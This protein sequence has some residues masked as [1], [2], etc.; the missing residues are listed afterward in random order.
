MLRSTL[1]FALTLACSMAATAQVYK[2]RKGSVVAYQDKP[3][4]R[5]TQLGK[6]TLEAAPVAGKTASS[7][8]SP[9][10]PVP[11]TPPASAAPAPLPQAQNYLCVRYDGSSYFTG[12]NM[13]RRHFVRG[14]DLKIPRPGVAPTTQ[15]WVTDECKV[16][17]L[18]DACTHYEVQILAL[19]QKQKSASASELK[20]LQRESRRLR[21]V[22]NSR[23]R[24]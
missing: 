3:C 18:K 13:P 5:G 24:G 10:L 8:I 9:P 21:T 22:S 2:C 15:L 1:L 7:S 4:P 23:C 17:P 6:I 16:A 14:A 11:S 12:S 20:A 19:D